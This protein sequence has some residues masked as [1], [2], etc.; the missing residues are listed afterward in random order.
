MSERDQILGRIREALK[1]PAPAVGHHRDGAA[2]QSPAGSISAQAR[3]WLPAVGENFAEQVAAFQ[4]KCAELR[5]DFHLVDSQSECVDLLTELRD[6]E[7]W[8]KIGAHQGKLIDFVCAKLDL[9]VCRT[10]K[11]YE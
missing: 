8:K 3:Q 6:R 10:D 7:Q 11:G 1:V 4:N 5:A 9:P 2:S